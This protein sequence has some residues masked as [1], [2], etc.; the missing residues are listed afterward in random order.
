M[1]QTRSTAEAQIRSAAAR[2]AL[3]GILAACRAAV[4]ACPDIADFWSIWAIT[5]ARTKSRALRWTPMPAPWR[6]AAP[7]RR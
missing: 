1:S 4:E 3:S 5:C 6:W 2:G 7:S